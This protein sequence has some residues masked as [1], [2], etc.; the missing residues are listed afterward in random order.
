MQN[1]IDH[2]ADDVLEGLIVSLV[3]RNWVSRV[4]GGNTT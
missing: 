1:F 3:Q 2:L 4:R